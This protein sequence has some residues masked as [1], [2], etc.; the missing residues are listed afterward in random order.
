[1]SQVRCF[2]QRLFRPF[3]GVMRTISIEHGDAET[4]DGVSWILYVNHEDIVSHTGMSE[5]R[6][7]SWSHEDGLSYL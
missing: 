6:Y 7:G 3:H 4:T 2:S 5:V 1:M